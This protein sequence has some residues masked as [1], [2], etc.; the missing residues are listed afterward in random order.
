MGRLKQISGRLGSAPLRLATLAPAD[1]ADRTKAR[2]DL[3]AWRAW[4]STAKWQRLR[5]SILVRDLFTCQR[6]GCGRI[7]ADTSQL[8]ADHI[9]PHRGDEAKFWDPLNLQ[10]LCKRCH[11]TVKQAEERGAR[12]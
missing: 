8:V 7:E 6:P 5:W 9:D 10:C 1:E 2:R 11:D 12:R 4:Y 3:H